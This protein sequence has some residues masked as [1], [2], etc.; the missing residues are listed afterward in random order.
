MCNQKKM[1]H[2]IMAKSPKIALCPCGTILVVWNLWPL[3]RICQVLRDPCFFFECAKVQRRPDFHLSKRHKWVCKQGRCS[4]LVWSFRLIKLW[5]ME[6]LHHSEALKSINTAYKHFVFWIQ[7]SPSD[8]KDL[9]LKAFKAKVR[10]VR[11]AVFIKTNNSPCDLIYAFI[12]GAFWCYS[13]HNQKQ[14]ASSK[15]ASYASNAVFSGNNWAS[16][17]QL[18]GRVEWSAVAAGAG[19]AEMF[20]NAH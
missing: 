4:S 13:Q 5:Q 2:G 15:L 7:K 20:S 11:G 3:I 6:K 10:A 19:D 9:C 16:R 1:G 8:W 14:K 18:A 17:D 12:M